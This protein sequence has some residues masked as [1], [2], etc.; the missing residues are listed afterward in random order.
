MNFRLSKDATMQA[1]GFGSIAVVIG[2]FFSWP[3]QLNSEVIIE[4]ISP[5]ANTWWR[6]LVLFLA[7]AVI[8]LTLARK[9]HIA[10]AE[11]VGTIACFV[12]LCPLFSVFAGLPK[13]LGWIALLLFFGGMTLILAVSALISIT[14]LQLVRR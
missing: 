4:A 10:L 11:Y 1:L 2:A 3:L 9:K 12:L 8:A 5:L 14:T 7:A 6:L 13:D